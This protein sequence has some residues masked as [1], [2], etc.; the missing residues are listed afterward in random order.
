MSSQAVRIEAIPALTGMRFIAA[1]MVFVSHYKIPGLQGT[2]LRLI[3]SGYSGITFFFVLSGFVLAYNYFGVF[4]QKFARSIP[5]YLIS[6]LARVYPLYLFC[7][8][9]AWLSSG[10]STPLIPYLGAVQAWSSSS[11][12]AFGLD[13]PTWSISVEAFL[14]LCFPVVFLV[15]RS[16]RIIDHKRRALALALVVVATQFTLA[17][18][19]VVS[20][21]GGVDAITTDPNSSHRWLYLNPANRLLDFSLGILT[22]VFVLQSGEP[23]GRA[24]R[25]WS[26]AI[27]L[28]L[29]FVVV[30]MAIKPIYMTAWSWDAVYALP[31]AVC[32]AGVALNQHSL[33]SRFLST[34]SMVTL[35]ASSYA[36]YLLHTLMRPIYSNASTS[37]SY[38]F[39]IAFLIFVVATSV[40]FHFA[41]EEP[42][43]RLVCST[44][45]GIF[46]LD[47]SVTAHASNVEAEYAKSGRIE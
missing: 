15:F 26:A 32:I 44:F 31:F 42:C 25:L 35:G 1:L 47:I 13:G 12:F 38:A 22:A 19:F 39:Y 20:G 17:Y 27:W 18:W 8:L 2:F 14:Y 46:R 7:T 45:A 11:A 37:N 34:Q 36:F 28:S 21:H 16:A 4:E 40:G 23:S 41:I 5:T 3:N 10:G 6:R 24:P 9:F 43:R 33:L 29:L 30:L